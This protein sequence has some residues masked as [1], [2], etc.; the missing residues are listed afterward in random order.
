MK[1]SFF[2]DLTKA[3]FRQLKKI[4]ADERVESAWTVSGAIRF[5]VTGD[6]TIFKVTSIYDTVD[7]VIE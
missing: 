3:S 7:D 6:D 1:Y 5:K 2:E 4:Q